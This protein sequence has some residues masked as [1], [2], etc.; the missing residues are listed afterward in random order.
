MCKTNGGT[1]NLAAAL[2]NG[3]YASGGRYHERC[4]APGD[5]AEVRPEDRALFCAGVYETHEHTFC[6][7]ITHT[8]E[9]WIVQAGGDQVGA[10]LDREH[11]HDT[12]ASLSALLT[13]AAQGRLVLLD[14]DG[15]PAAPT[16]IVGPRPDGP[17]TYGPVVTVGGLTM[18]L[19]DREVPPQIARLLAPAIA[20]QFELAKLTQDEAQGAAA[21]AVAALALASE[22]L[23]RCQDLLTEKEPK[24][25]S[26]K[27]SKGLAL[28][29]Q[30]EGAPAL[31]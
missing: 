13:A 24:G 26:L 12:G 18:M 6:G 27:R 22:M 1:L 2:L 8:Q 31:A 10:P 5:S 19:E 16:R 15:A 28:E 14:D 25:A 11:P 17:R 30:Q 20:H 23:E 7:K 3:L 4:V 29:V 21:G 9:V